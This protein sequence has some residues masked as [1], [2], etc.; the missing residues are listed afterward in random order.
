MSK[1]Q[2]FL[3]KYAKTD[4]LI[5]TDLTQYRTNNFPLQKKINEIARYDFSVSGFA[6]ERR[7]EEHRIVSSSCRRT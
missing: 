7:T 4:I 2:P 6:P 5:A 1:M 3:C